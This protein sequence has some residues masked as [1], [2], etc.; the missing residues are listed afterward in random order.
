MYFVKKNVSLSF[1]YG[2][3]LAAYFIL[4]KAET[5]I[6]MGCAMRS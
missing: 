5:I 2:I 1:I 3:Y 4:K 6:W